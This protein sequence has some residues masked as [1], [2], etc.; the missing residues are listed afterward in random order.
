MFRTFIV[1]IAAMLAA[2]AQAVVVDVVIRGDIQRLTDISSGSLNLFGGGLVAGAAFTARFTYD[3]SLGVRRTDFNGNPID[4][5]S[6]STDGTLGNPVAASLTIGQTRRNLL[7]VSALSN[8]TEGGY[9]S[10]VPQAPDPVFPPDDGFG[11]GNPRPN[12]AAYGVYYTAY[13]STFN[14]SEHGEFKFNFEGA[15][16]T[17]P[18]S[19]ETPFTIGFRDNPQNL[20]SIPAGFGSWLTG[21]QDRA[22]VKNGFIIANFTVDRLTIRP[23][24]M[25]S[26]TPVPLPATVVLFA[27]SLGLLGFIA[28]RRRKISHGSMC[29]G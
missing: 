20:S 10:L 27:T 8:V 28:S 21:Y 13:D 25:P 26:P 9:A 12:L 17:F 1:T 19:L 22:A 16:G 2:P 5:L 4:T 15:V 3:T 11:S 24:G 29:V 7:G 6:G 18:D 14:L 23:R